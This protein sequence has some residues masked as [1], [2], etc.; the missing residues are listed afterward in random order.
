[1]TA[2]VYLILNK[3]TGKP[4]IGSTVNLVC[5]K[6]EH[7]SDLRN[8]RHANRKLAHSWGVHGDAAFEFSVLLICA[9]KDLEFYEQ[10]VMDAY[11]SVENGYNIVPFAKKGWAIGM[12]H[13]DD[14]KQKM[15]QKATGR[16]MSRESVE[17]SRLGNIGKV[18]GRKGIPI[19]P[20]VRAKISA[21]LKGNVLPPH[22]PFHNSWCK[23]LKLG[24][25]SDEHKRK[26][27]AAW[28]PALRAK[29]SIARAMFRDEQV[30]EFRRR[31]DGGETATALARD[32]G[33]GLSTMH[34]IVTRKNYKHVEEH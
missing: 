28:T 14:A 30:A 19:P 1:M 13:S 5:R 26:L 7:F 8:K 3:V 24:P 21:K 10:H 15:A 16:V 23:G 31:F 4:Y 33:C 17:K 18:T 29:L 9:K 12:R 22:H 34:R 2:G 32:V 27:V 20:E 11:D 6:R 25:R